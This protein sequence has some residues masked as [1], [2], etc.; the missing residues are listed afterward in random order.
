MSSD[1]KIYVDFEYNTSAKKHTF[2][3]ISLRRFF[4]KYTIKGFLPIGYN[5]Q[6]KSIQGGLFIHI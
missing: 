3:D 1:Y 6:S 2:F 5:D 4:L